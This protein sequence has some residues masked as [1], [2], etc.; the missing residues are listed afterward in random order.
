MTKSKGTVQM[1]D[2]DHTNSELYKEPP[3]LAPENFIVSGLTDSSAILSWDQA[4]TNTKALK[5]Y[6]LI[7][8]QPSKTPTTN[9]VKQPPYTL[10][11]LLPC[12]KYSATLYAIS[13]AA[14]N[15]YGLKTSPLIFVTK[16]S[17][18]RG[19]ISVT[20]QSLGPT[21]GRLVVTESNVAKDACGQYVYAIEVMNPDG[22]VFTQLQ[23]TRKTTDIAGLTPNT[24][25]TTSAAMKEITTG[26]SG[27]KTTG[28]F[29]TDAESATSVSKPGPTSFAALDIT[30]DSVRLLWTA[31]PQVKGYTVIKYEILYTTSD[32]KTASVDTSIV[33]TYVLKGLISCETY[34]IAI[35]SVLQN[36][37]K[38]TDIM[39]SD[40]SR[41]VIVTIRAST[42]A[43]VD[44]VTATALSSSL[45][46][47]TIVDTVQRGSCAVY[48]Y[49]T[50]I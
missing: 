36:L 13:D 26:V 35:R 20:F 3:Y 40:Y 37:A 15:Q 32:G 23:S 14:T 42:T 21:Q 8:E 50:A 48:S 5:E 33:T 39:N 34:S 43:T 31:S 9:L 30:G 44:S 22:T 49:N 38:P 2:Y 11:E 1:V 41:S 47:V 45:A 29:K 19:T 16:P 6:G 28:N 12:N 46:Q 24:E 18:V 27:T 4:K 7:I 25:Y 17:A 10:T